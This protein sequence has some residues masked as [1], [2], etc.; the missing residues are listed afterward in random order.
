ML[1]RRSQ[2][3]TPDGPVPRSNWQLF[4]ERFF[5]HKVAW[6]SAIVLVVLFVVCFGA[7]W[8][9]PYPKNH[10]DPLLIAD[11]HG[12]SAKHW[13][14]TT[15]AGEDV[16][17]QVL[18]GG[19]VSLKIGLTVALLSTMVGVLVGAV[20]GFFGRWI[21]QGLSRVTDLFLI[22]PEIALL[23]LAL[24]KLGHTP[25]WIIVVLAALGWMY[26]ARVVRGQVMSLKEKEFVEAARAT[27]ASNRRIV[28]RHILPNCVG[29]I[30]VNMTLAVATAIVAESSLSF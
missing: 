29:S 13:F 15:D 14:G 27:G 17:T 16:L 18:Y 9:A 12:P 20:A 3:A 1:P 6:I 4:R 5:R 2:P 11:A 26:I 8:V 21:D 28:L 23:A 10:I 22:V 24:K 25:S 19:Q 30:T 7:S